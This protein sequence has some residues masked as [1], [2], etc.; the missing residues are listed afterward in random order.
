MADSGTFFGDIAGEGVSFAGEVEFAPNMVAFMVPRGHYDDLF[1]LTEAGQ[2][3]LA[4]DPFVRKEGWS[5]GKGD[6]GG[7]FEDVEA[8]SGAV[9][10]LGEFGY[11]LS[12][13]VGAGGQRVT[14]GRV[15]REVGAY[16]DSAGDVG[17]FLGEDTETLAEGQG[18]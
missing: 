9:D 14:D 12:A 15:F 3:N 1:G 5:P 10:T 11:N 16:A 6:G 2:V 4:P 8:E 13:M 18:F 17:H 7:A